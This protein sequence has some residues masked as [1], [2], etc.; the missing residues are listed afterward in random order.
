MSDQE[1][2]SELLKFKDVIAKLRH[3]ESG[4][5]WD[6][7]QTHQSLLKFLIEESYEF[8]NA[9]EEHDFDEMRDELGDILLQVFLHSQ[10]ASEEKHFSLIDV[11][12]SISDK[13]IRRHPHV[14]CNESDKSIEEIKK[15]WEEIKQAEKSQKPQKKYEINAEHMAFPS[16]TSSYKIGKKTNK[17][18]FDWGDYK[19]VVEKVEEEWAE[20]KVE[21][22]PEVDMNKDRVYEELGDTLFTIAQLARHLDI[23]PEICLRDANLKFKRRFNMVEDIA[24][25]RNVLIKEA[26]KDKLESLW[27]EVK[28]IE[29]G[30]SL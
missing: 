6:L 11:V 13:M 20:L 5:P 17:M 4:C 19:Q 9:V 7:E 3:P 10:L 16:L 15:K 25:K 27:N 28:T 30:N 12:K 14:F 8:S 21:L 2:A 18:N 23:D 26:S 24:K 1:L 29:R 22:T